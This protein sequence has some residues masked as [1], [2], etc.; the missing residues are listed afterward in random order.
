MAPASNTACETSLSATYKGQTNTK[1]FTQIIS[2]PLPDAKTSPPD[3]KAKVGYL[4]G[5]R[6]STKRLQDEIN[7][8]LTEKMEEDK[9][10]IATSEIAV[11]G[12]MKRGFAEDEAE[13][14]Y[15]EDEDES[16]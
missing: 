12:D 2:S 1:V 6:A 3:T 13:E 10:N 5:L 9:A 11:T 16:S 4:S 8:F 15:G 14:T 7:T